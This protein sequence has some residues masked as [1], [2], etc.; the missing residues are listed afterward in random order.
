MSFSLSVFSLLELLTLD[1]N[2]STGI[3]LCFPLLNLLKVK[4]LEPV[5]ELKVDVF[6][7]AEAESESKGEGN[8]ILI[9][10]NFDNCVLP[11]LDLRSLLI[12]P[13]VASLT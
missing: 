4:N 10:E 5:L 3:S 9:S 11:K 12:L 2:L 6:R 8:R 1:L 7:L 13:Q